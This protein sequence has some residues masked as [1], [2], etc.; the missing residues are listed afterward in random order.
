L[1]PAFL[2]LSPDFP[3]ALCLNSLYGGFPK[4]D[5]CETHRSG[6]SRGILSVDIFR[7]PAGSGAGIVHQ[8]FNAA[9][10]E[11]SSEATPLQKAQ[12]QTPARL[13]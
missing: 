10:V 5:S 11:A 4:G 13:T 8:S 3:P 1:K 6:F 9:R 2:F 7:R 12:W